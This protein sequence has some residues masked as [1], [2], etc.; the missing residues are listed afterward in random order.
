VADPE[1]TTFEQYCRLVI[2][3]FLPEKRRMRSVNLPLFVGRLIGAPSTL[4]SNLLGRDQPL[5]DPTLYSLYS[6]C[7][8]LDFSTR[9]IEGLFARHGEPFVRR[10]E[11]FS[12]EG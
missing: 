12:E 4:L 6:T 1:V 3:H 10:E 9:E 7:L 2:G 11:G 8:N 5:W